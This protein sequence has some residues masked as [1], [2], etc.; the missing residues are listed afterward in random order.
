M[1][2][3]ARV[4]YVVDGDYSEFETLKQVLDFA[5]KYELA[6]T[7]FDIAQTIDSSARFMVTSLP[8]NDLRDRTLH[9]RLRYLEALISMIGP[10]ACTLQARTSFG[11][12][13][14]EIVSEAARGRHDLVI[15]RREKGSTDKRV[16]RDCQCPVWVLGPEDYTASGQIITSNAP[17]MASRY[18][19]QMTRA[20]AQ[21]T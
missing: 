4:L 19:N 21:G 11:N 9:N 14:R 2:H 5:E 1:K 17:S 3:Y 6:L 18:E 10:R 12:R 20:C 16:R 13:A 8:L 7:L 15:K